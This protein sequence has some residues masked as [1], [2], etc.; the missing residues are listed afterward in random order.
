[1]HLVFGRGGRQARSALL[2]GTTEK[3]EPQGPGFF[4]GRLPE[5]VHA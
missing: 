5:E 2:A 4:A 1:M 3:T